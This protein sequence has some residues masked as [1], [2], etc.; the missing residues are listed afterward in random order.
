MSLPPMILIMEDYTMMM[1]DYML[2]MIDDTSLSWA[3]DDIYETRNL[4]VETKQR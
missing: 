2:H 4:D 1:K 3:H